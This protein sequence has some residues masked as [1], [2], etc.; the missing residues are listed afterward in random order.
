MARANQFHPI[1]RTDVRIRRPPL[2]LRTGSPWSSTHASRSG[3]SAGADLDTLPRPVGLVESLIHRPAKVIR[4][5]RL[6]QQPAS[7]RLG[8][9]HVFPVR[10][11]GDDD[12]GNAAVRLPVQAAGKLKAVEVAGQPEVGDHDAGKHPGRRHE[13]QGTMGV[14]DRVRP[15]PR[16]L[17]QL[18]EAERLE[19]VILD[20]EDKTI[21][22]G[23]A[24][25]FA[26]TVATLLAGGV[27]KAIAMLNTVPLPMADR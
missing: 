27:A 21:I 26:T 1:S 6:V 8:L 23:L 24:G 5:V 10:V 3:Y 12:G 25:V 15:V 14:A 7:R 9:L 13:L 17:E 4:A 19:H 11:A 16:T 20:D 22:R 18:A 2:G